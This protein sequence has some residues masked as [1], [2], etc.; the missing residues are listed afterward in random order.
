MVYDNQLVCFF[1]PSRDGAHSQKLSY[2]TSDDLIAWS[3]AAD[4]VAY[5]A[6]EDRPGMPTVAYIP[7]TGQYVLTYEYCGAEGCGIFYRRSPSPL[8]FGGASDNVVSPA[9]TVPSSLG[10]S[11]YMIW[12][13]H[14]DRADGSGLLILSTGG[15]DEVFL[16]EDASEPASWRPVSVGMQTAYSRGLSVITINGQKK[17]Q[18]AN[19]GNMGDPDENFIST[20]IV[21]IPT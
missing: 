15:K 9:D 18:F 20:G 7:P 3:G 11:P 17:L 4:A 13:E 2:A 8:T 14:P 21:E 10:G 12:T 19:G 16:N 1:S 5:S 6:Y